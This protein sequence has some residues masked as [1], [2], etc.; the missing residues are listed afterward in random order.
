MWA[1]ASSARR[2]RNMVFQRPS[3]QPSANP[4]SAE[5]VESFDS[6]ADVVDM[7]V[8]ERKIQGEEE[9]P[10]EQYFGKWQVDLEIQA[11]PLVHGFSAPRECAANLTRFQECA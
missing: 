8:G 3:S 11:R 4:L 10:L 2:M 5:P 7:I 6:V 1:I 9:H